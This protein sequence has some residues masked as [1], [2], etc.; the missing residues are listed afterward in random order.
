MIP[1]VLYD[2]VLRDALSD[3]YVNVVDACPSLS[4]RNDYYDA[5]DLVVKELPPGVSVRL[6]RLS[7]NSAQPYRFVTVDHVA[8]EAHLEGLSI[9]SVTTGLLD[10]SR[11]RIIDHVEQDLDHHRRRVEVAQGADPAKNDQPD[12]EPACCEATEHIS[13]FD[14]CFDEIDAAEEV[15]H[16]P[17]TASLEDAPNEAGEPPLM[18]EEC[19]VDA[20]PVDAPEIAVGFCAEEESNPLPQAQRPARV[21]RRRKPSSSLAAVVQEDVEAVPD[22]VAPDIHTEIAQEHPAD[23]RQDVAQEVAAPVAPPDWLTA[24][25]ANGS[26]SPEDILKK[27]CDLKANQ[28]IR[29]IAREPLDAISQTYD[30][31]QLHGYIQQWRQKTGPG[32]KR[33]VRYV[34]IDDDG[35]ESEIRSF[36]PH[37]KQIDDCDVLIYDVAVCDDG[38][39]A[40]MPR[41]TI[42][43]NVVS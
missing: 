12:D 15:T 5:V 29:V 42:P 43:A 32:A 9:R 17:T 40:T 3:D 33:C 16:A 8:R 7:G 31:V 38:P 30:F 10:A 22:D 1:S 13:V 19:P 6:V 4:T 21:T 14:P 24:M 18:S 35:D 41:W 27:V 37:P 11:K 23:S 34:A 25:I 2:E 26:M 36:L 20:Q 28:P 39:I